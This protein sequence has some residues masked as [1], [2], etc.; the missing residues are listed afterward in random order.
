LKKL[1]F[2]LKAPS[3]YYSEQ[4]YFDSKYTEPC[5]SIGATSNKIKN[6]MDYYAAMTFVAK[7]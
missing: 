1:F 2:L 7:C 5:L 4:F 3:L 6:V